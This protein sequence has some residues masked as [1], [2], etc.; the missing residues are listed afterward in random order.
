ME[1]VLGEVR[2]GDLGLEAPLTAFRID[3]SAEIQIVCLVKFCA[4]ECPLV[5]RVIL[6]NG[7]AKAGRDFLFNLTKII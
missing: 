5:G 7:F 3:G 4:A 2:R 6:Q 1:Q